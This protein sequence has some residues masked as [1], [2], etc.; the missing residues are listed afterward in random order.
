[1]EVWVCTTANC[2]RRHHL[3]EFREGGKVA[4]RRDG[5]R[6][7]GDEMEAIGHLPS[8]LKPLALRPAG[9]VHLEA[10]AVGQRHS[11]QRALLSAAANQARDNVQDLDSVHSITQRCV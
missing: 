9:E 8:P 6:Q 4:Q 3:E 2:S 1:M 11:E 5:I 7:V 10:V